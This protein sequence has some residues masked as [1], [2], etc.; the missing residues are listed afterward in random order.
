MNIHSIETFGTHEG[1]GIRFVIFTQGCN[2]K[3]LYCHNPDSQQLERQVNSLESK[4]TSHGN[5]SIEELI[6]MIENN[7]PYFG[8]KGGVTVSGGEPLLQA[9]E[10]GQLFKRL[11]NTA[12]YSPPNLGGET[13]SS[14]PNLG[15]VRGGINTALDTNGSILND[16]VKELLKY[17]DLVLLDIK[18]IDP[19]EH[20]KITN[21]ELRT[22][23][24]QLQT[25]DI[26]RDGSSRVPSILFADYL[27]SQDI[28]F[29]IR[30]VFVPGY[31]DQSEFLVKTAEALKKYKS[32]ERIEILP[33]HTMG[34]DKYEKL[35][36]DYKLTGV[37]PPTAKGLASAKQIFE[38]SGKLVI[39][40]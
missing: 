8:E 6:A 24:S 19:I 35:G 10:V 40:R 26:A 17:T 36:W 9:K 2:Y 37:E 4:V 30:Y 29:W 1:P 39:I 32:L 13:I 7:R 14:P 28:P 33:Y 25:A 34:A 38:K 12:P 23:N 21:P 11:K 3:C 5:Y 18:H 16:D 31:T 20:Q 15:G 22:P 27:D